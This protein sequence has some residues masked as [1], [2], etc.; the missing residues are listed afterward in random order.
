M[1]WLDTKIWSR[2][3]FVRIK[4]VIIIM[5]NL[6][7]LRNFTMWLVKRSQGKLGN[8]MEKS[9]RLRQGRPLVGIVEK[10]KKHW[11]NTIQ[12]NTTQFNLFQFLS[13][14][15]YCNLSLCDIG[16]SFS[17]KVSCCL[18]WNGVYQFSWLPQ[19]C[20]DF[21][22]SLC[23]LFKKSEHTCQWCHPTFF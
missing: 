21:D 9:S 15:K 5:V 22:S 6:M 19:V 23:C 12:Y 10:K 1:I 18:C 17:G 20:V 8:E 13:S 11:M 14:F 7:Q 3:N 2:L 4:K 16:S